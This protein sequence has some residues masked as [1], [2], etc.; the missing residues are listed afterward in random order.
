MNKAIPMTMA[1]AA[2]LA[3]LVAGCAGAPAAV[4]QP[5][6]QPEPAAAAQPAAAAELQPADMS[7]YQRAGFVVKMEDGRL[8]VFR[9]GSK[10]LAEFEQKGEPVRQVIRPLA[11]PGGITLKAVDSETLDEYL[12]AYQGM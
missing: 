1:A 3:A 10:E 7:R 2:L 8:W 9:A 5:A 11:G 6:A 4:E 12:A